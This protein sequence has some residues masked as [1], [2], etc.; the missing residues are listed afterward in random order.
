LFVKQTPASLPRPKK[1]RAFSSRSVLIMC[2]TLSNTY[3]KSN[4]FFRMF[5]VSGANSRRQARGGGGGGFKSL[6][7]TRQEWAGV[8]RVE[9][10]SRCREGLRPQRVVVHFASEP[11]TQMFIGSKC[12]AAFRLLQ[13]YF[14]QSSAA[15]S[16]AKSL[17]VTYCGLL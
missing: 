13:V 8:G 9:S 10:L 4:V 12:Y 17:V 1:Q 14:E 3:G 16:T 2:L 6:V 11:Q 5:S 15:M 7:W